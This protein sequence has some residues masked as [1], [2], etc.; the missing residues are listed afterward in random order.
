MSKYLPEF[1]VVG[2]AKAGTTSVY[3]YLK[4]HPQVC[5]PC[6]E[7]K[8][9]N[10]ESIPKMPTGMHALS[11]QDYRQAYQDAVTPE[12]RVCGEVSTS[13]LYYH[14]EAI[15]KIKAL[16]GDVKIIIVLRNPVE[17]AWSNYLFECANFTETLSF[18]D[19]LDAE[20][21]RIRAQEFFMYYYASLGLYADQVRAWKENFS[22][23]KVWL[24]EDMKQESFLPDMYRFVGVDPEFCPA[25]SGIYN[26]SGVPK[27][28]LL[29]QM[30]F[31][32]TTL[33][34]RIRAVLS[35]LVG[36]DRLVRA[37]NHFRNRN[38]QKKEMPVECC[39]RLTDLYREDIQTLQDLIGRDLS[40]WL[41]D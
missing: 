27:N 18:E 35:R 40:S 34:I 24:L 22:N 39:R 5:I 20:P 1:I 11:E 14:R 41:V 36:E 13:Y 38:L 9:F 23:V 15:P 4:A 26:A 37:I 30:F 12:T 8:F 2:A 16:L 17:R 32:P 6:K 31:R 21:E 28:R 33:N 10:A 7:T 3:N 25:D 29:H 19:A